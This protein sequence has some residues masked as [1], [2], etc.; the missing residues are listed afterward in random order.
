MYIKNNF[1]YL[2]YTIYLRLCCV[3]LPFCDELI[4]KDYLK[5]KHFHTYDY[6]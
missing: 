5:Y 2:Y 3:K 6:Y 4:I 1:K